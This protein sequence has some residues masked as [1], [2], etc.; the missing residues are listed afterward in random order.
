MP[1]SAIECKS[2]CGP[3]EY[4][5][6]S[7]FFSMSFASRSTADGEAEDGGDPFQVTAL[8]ATIDKIGMGKTL[9]VC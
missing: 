3:W 4:C 8:D 9:G 1:R 7:C 6:H 5:D 2:S